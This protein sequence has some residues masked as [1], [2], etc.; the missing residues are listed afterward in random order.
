MN[1]NHSR[2]RDEQHVKKFCDLKP[3]E[4]TWQVATAVHNR[5]DV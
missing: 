2:K 5:L 3:A 4:S 1:E